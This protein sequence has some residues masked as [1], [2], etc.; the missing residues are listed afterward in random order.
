M[1]KCE[2]K[3]VKAEEIVSCLVRYGLASQ[4]PYPYEAIRKTENG[5]FYYDVCG[6]NMSVNEMEFD[7]FTLPHL[8][9]KVLR[10]YME[11]AKI[12]LEMNGVSDIDIGKYVY[13]DLGKADNNSITQF[14]NGT[15]WVVSSYAHRFSADGTFTTLV[16]CFT[17]YINREMDANHTTAERQVQ[18][19]NEMSVSLNSMF[20]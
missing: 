12:T 14:V 11:Y 19:G 15:K 17:P 20:S 16:E 2:P 3:D 10:A 6:I 1:A 9:G 5:V 7:R 8:K 4:E 18:I 13:I